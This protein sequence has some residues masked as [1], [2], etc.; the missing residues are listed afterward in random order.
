MSDSAVRQR[1]RQ[2]KSFVG[3]YTLSSCMAAGMLAACG[4]SQPPIGKRDRKIYFRWEAT[5]AKG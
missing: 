1:A 4:G 5:G 2:M 3:R